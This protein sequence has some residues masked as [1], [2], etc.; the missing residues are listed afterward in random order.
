[1]AKNHV[2]RGYAQKMDGQLGDVALHVATSLNGNGNFITPPLTPAAIT[3]QATALN[4]A[5]AKAI[6]GTPADTLDKNTKRDALIAALD[7]LA[8][9]V[10]L[11]AGNDP[12][13]ILSSGFELASTTRQQL[14]PGMTS[15]MS[16]TNVASGKL[17]LDLQV[18]NNAWAYVVEYTALP[19]GAVK[20]ATFTN[21]HDVVLEGLTPGSVYSMRVQVMGSANQTSEW[22]DSV[23]HM[24]T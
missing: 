8:N 15:I 6:H 5:V 17:G 18:A 16:V 20:T 21:P 11:M 1:M 24:S 9:Y 23:S 22:C 12:Q 10:E 7:M 19:N 4:V 14:A 13:K 3:T 2:L